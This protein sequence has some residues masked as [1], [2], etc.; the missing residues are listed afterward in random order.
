MIKFVHTLF[1]VVNLNLFYF[2]RCLFVATILLTITFTLIKPSP[3]I[4]LPEYRG[5]F[6]KGQNNQGYIDLSTGNEND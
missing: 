2:A 6:W 4:G 5:A 1:I 3:V